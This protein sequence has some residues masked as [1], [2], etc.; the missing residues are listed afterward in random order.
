M[1]IWIRTQNRK[2]LVEVV[3]IGLEERDFE[4]TIIIVGLNKSLRKE[5]LR[6]I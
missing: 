6:R 5:Y 3:G 1:G 4:N 2:S